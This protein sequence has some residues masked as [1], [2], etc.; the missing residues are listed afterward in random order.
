MSETQLATFGTGCFWCSEALFQQLKGVT[1]VESGYSGGP[2]VDPS[3]EQV[4]SGTTGH[5]EVIQVEFD[6]TQISYADLLEVFWHVHDPTTLNRQGADIGP[7]Y[8]SI[9]F[10]HNEDQ[11]KVAEDSKIKANAE[12]IYPDPIVTEVKE[13][14]AFYPAGDYH[15]DYYLNHQ[16]QPYC[17]LVID[18]KVAKFR[19][20]FGD[21]LNSNA[22]KL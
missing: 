22:T 4:S 1:K 7:Q 14:S 11:R 8:R 20:E 9:I 21:K 16:N 19:K 17:K 10:Y 3:Y 6:P 5:A 13:F 15:K 12:K 2:V 18:P